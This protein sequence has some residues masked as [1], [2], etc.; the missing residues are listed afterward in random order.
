MI[1]CTV[2]KVDRSL[3]QIISTS[4]FFDHTCKSAP[5]SSVLVLTPS[6]ATAGL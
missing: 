2:E 5:E 6:G 3:G 1:V 4:R